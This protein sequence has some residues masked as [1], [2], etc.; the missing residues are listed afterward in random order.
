MKRN[1]LAI[2]ATLAA[3]GLTAAAAAAQQMWAPGGVPLCQSG[4]PGDVPHIVPDGANGVFVAWRDVRNSDDVFLQRVTGLGFI[5]PGWPLGGLPIIVNPSAE[6]LSGFA[7]DGLGGVLVAW[8]E[9]RNLAVTGLDPYVQRVLADG[10]LP[11]GWVVGGTAASLNPADQFTP[12]VAPDGAGGAYVAWYDDRNY[13]VTSYD[14]YAQHLMSSGAIAPGWPQDGLALC[15]LPGEQAYPVAMPDD[16]GGAVFIWGDGR[17]GA[18]GS[19]ALRVNVDGTRAPGWPIDGL[20]LSSLGIQKAVRDEAGGFYGVGAT[21]TNGFDGAYYLY[22][23]TFDGTAAAGWPAGGVLV[24]NAPGIRA[25]ISLASDGAGG[26]LLCWYDYRPPYNLTGGEIF[27]L[28]VLPDGTLAPGWTVDGTLLSDPT[29]GLQ[30]YDPFAVRDG[31]GG[32]YVVWQSQGGCCDPSWIQH[33]TGS[34]Q[35]MAGWPRYGLRVAPSGA[36]VDTRIATDGQGGAIV[37]WD[38]ACCGRIGVWAQRFGPEGVVPVLVSLVNATAREGLVALGWYAAAGAGLQAS[39]Y[40]RTR[41]R[42]WLTL[43]TVS[44]DGTG[45]MHY[46]DRAVSPGE[47]YAYRLGYMEG[48]VE[49]FSAETWVDVPALALALE[50]FRP[51][52]AMGSPTISFTLPGSGPAR[53]EVFDVTGRQMFGEDVGSLSGGHHEVAATG[54]RFAPGLYVVRLSGAGRTLS[55]RGVVTR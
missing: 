54:V 36:Q 14:V 5:A 30:S 51:N 42:G 2:K 21:A 53:L 22:R 17:P 35:V 39:V 23:F 45:H 49:Q 38:E 20:L 29:D 4:C 10:S 32:G 37:A 52:P 27:A 40:R 31:Q 47:H 28:R 3:L 19:Y 24:C 12:A 26:V 11:S 7:P 16:S 8:E 50:G 13:A 18:P 6:E 33:L 43:G 41:S 34:G 15:A 55:T 44:A 25:G 46:D 48:A 1:C 9:W